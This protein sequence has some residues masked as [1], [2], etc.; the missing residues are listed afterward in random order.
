MATVTHHVST[1]DTGASPNTSGSFTPAADDL[2]AVFVVAS[3]TDGLN[4]TLTGSGGLSFT[5][6]ASAAYGGGIDRIELWAANTLAAASAQTVTWED[7]VDQ[8]SGTVISVFSIA[9]MTRT[10][11]SAVRQ[12]AKQEE[13]GGGGT[14]TP[15]FAS[16]CLTGNP[17]IGCVANHTNP[18]GLT[19]P[20][21]W[22]EPVGG[23]V[24]YASPNTGAE[25]VFRD[26]GFTG[27]TVTWGGT[28]ASA[29]GDLIAEFDTSAAAAQSPFVNPHALPS[30]DLPPGLVMPPP[31]TLGAGLLTSQPPFF[32]QV[33]AKRVS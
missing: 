16:A 20:T 1:A 18:A 31:N 32:T 22:T 13:Q 14:P 12:S 15:V 23:D 17:T 10:G 11:S 5:K 28:S 27:T 9:G 30:P 4:A 26:S 25:V 3:G 6:I 8:S 19:P 7:T 21:D 33:G 24:G 2:L 29:F